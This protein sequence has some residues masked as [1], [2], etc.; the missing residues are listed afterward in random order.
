MHLAVR[1]LS[2]FG[3]NYWAQINAGAQNCEASPVSRDIAI[4]HDGTTPRTSTSHLN[5]SGATPAKITVAEAAAARE[6]KSG[7]KS[8][9]RLLSQIHYSVCSVRNPSRHLCN[10]LH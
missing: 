10:E 1:G 4:E 3:C 7:S 5:L 2:I 8:G 6:Q 9:N